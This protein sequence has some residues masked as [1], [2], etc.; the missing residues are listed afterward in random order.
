MRVKAIK[1]EDFVNYKLP[2]MYIATCFCDWKCCREAN[3]SE[4][5]CQNNEIASLPTID[6]SAE[7]IF[8]RYINNPITESIVIAGLE[9]LLQ[10][11]ELTEL[12]MYFREH[13]CND[14]F[15]IYTGYNLE[16]VEPYLV[17]IKK[18]GNLIFKFG[19]YIPGHKPHY[20][21]VLGVELASDNQ[22]GVYYAENYFKP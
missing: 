21:N 1:D 7:S 10:R 15:V 8:R 19:R 22:R 16:E 5:V 13:G 3:I 4:S 11:R 12:I 2:C 17:L 18:F 9:P 20:D 6:I 14:P